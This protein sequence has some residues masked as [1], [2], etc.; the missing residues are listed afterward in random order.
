MLKPRKSE[1]GQ[2]SCFYAY[3]HC[4]ASQILVTGD[5]MLVLPGLHELKNCRPINHKNFLGTTT[6]SKNQLSVAASHGTSSLFCDCTW[7]FVSLFVVFFIVV[8]PQLFFLVFFCFQIV[9]QQ[10]KKGRQ[11]QFLETRFLS[12]LLFG[13]EK[14][15][16]FTLEHC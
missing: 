4:R 7:V 14:S 12:I 16:H 15:V 9:K 6:S 13:T 11:R 2:D 10:T 8:F 3:C 1:V 5:A